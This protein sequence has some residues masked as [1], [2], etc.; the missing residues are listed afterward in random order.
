MPKTMVTIQGNDFYINGEKVYSEFEN[1]DSNIYGLLMNARFIQGIFDDKENPEQF[2]RFGRTFDSDKNTNDLIEA[3]PEWYQYGLRA[4]TVGLQGG[5]PCFT[6]NNKN[7]N[8]NPFSE[9][10]TSIDAAYLSRLDQLIKAA[11]DI[12]MI[13]IVSYFYPGQV[14]RLKDGQTVIN[15]VKAASRFLKEQAYTNVLIEVCN[16]CDGATSHPLIYEDECM[17]VLINIAREESGG[18][19]VSASFR[20]NVITP[21]ICK[22]S[23]FI[24]IH[25]NGTSRTKYQR[26]LEKAKVYG[27]DK[28]IICNEDSPALYKADI[29]I[30]NHVSW[31]Y[32]NNLSKQEPPTDWSMHKGLDTYYM[33]RIAKKLGIELEREIEPLCFRGFDEHEIFENRC[34][35]RVAALFPEKILKVE[36]YKNEQLLQTSYDE[37]FAYNVHDETLP[38]NVLS[39]WRWG[40]GVELEGDDKEKWKAIVYKVNGEKIEIKPD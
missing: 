4:F 23:D 33:M 15:A 21:Q 2:N 34:W 40:K 6:I 32:Y 11:D 5:G 29:S 19:P 13:V 17:P 30:D 28:P 25:G 35:P 16:E 24:T 10:G 36:F 31:G 1:A 37:P 14:S 3:L 20:G 8:C 9:D 38:Y 18:I 22:A 7:I 27:G 12:G 26:L 39:D